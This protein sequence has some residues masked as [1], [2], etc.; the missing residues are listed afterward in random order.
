MFKDTKKGQTHFYGDGCIEHSDKFPKTLKEEI[1]SIIAKSFKEKFDSMLDDCSVYFRGS[2][3]Y[4]DQ[5]I[6]SLLNRLPKE[7]FD[8][9][10]KNYQLKT[11]WNSCRQEAIKIITGKEIKEKR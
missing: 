4:A 9:T 3:E 7:M 1:S 10:D 6:Q 8:G 2:E 5:I 11:G